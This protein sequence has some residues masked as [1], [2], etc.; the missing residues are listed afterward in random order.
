MYTVFIFILLLFI[1]YCVFYSLVSD[2]RAPVDSKDALKAPW[3]DYIENLHVY[4]IIII[5]IIIII[6]FFK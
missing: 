2:L 4:F 1:F 3:K 5:I 6:S